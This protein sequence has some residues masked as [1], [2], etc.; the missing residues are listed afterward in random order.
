MFSIFGKQHR[1]KPS[2]QWRDVLDIRLSSYIREPKGTSDQCIGLW[3]GSGWFGK[4]SL[5]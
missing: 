4:A 5:R 1:V 3:Q 2:D